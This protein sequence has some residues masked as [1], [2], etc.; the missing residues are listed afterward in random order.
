VYEARPPHGYA[1]T[2]EN[3][4]NQQRRF[5]VDLP[6]LFMDN[7]TP[8]NFIPGQISIHEMLS[9]QE[10]P[11]TTSLEPPKKTHELT[12]VEPLRIAQAIMGGTIVSAGATTDGHTMCMEVDFGKDGPPRL[13]INFNVMEKVWVVAYVGENL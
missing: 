6:R 3:Q 12:L 11:R 2:N 8:P 7:E 1:V 10:N 5:I 9:P 13:V 4:T